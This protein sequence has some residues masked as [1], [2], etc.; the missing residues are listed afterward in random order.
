[1][2]PMAF[3]L[4][5]NAEEQQVTVRI[6]KAGALYCA[7]VFGAGFAL[8]PVRVVWVV[9]RLGERIAELTEMPIMFVVIV[10]AAH[11]TCRRLSVPPLPTRRL[12]MGVAALVLLLVL[13]FTVVLLIRGV[14]LSDYIA[15]RDPVAGTVYVLM[16]G[17]YAMMPMLVARR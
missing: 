2:M 17:V 7:L 13:E 10:L 15:N 12:M 16:L 8:G 9:P 14:T 6:L 1:M 11:W 5:D 4:P 3:R